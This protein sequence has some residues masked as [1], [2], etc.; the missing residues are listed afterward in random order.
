MSF[1]SSASQAVLMQIMRG[2]SYPTGTAERTFS[3]GHL[4]DGVFV[5]DE[6]DGFEAQLEVTCTKDGEPVFVA[7]TEDSGGPLTI[8]PDEI[9]ISFALTPEETE[10]L[11]FDCCQFELF[12]YKDSVDGPIEKRPVVHGE[13]SVE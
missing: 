7:S 5:V 11:E 1:L 8:D 12:I 4:I 2:Y 3:Y 13:M 10:E 6:N 9:I